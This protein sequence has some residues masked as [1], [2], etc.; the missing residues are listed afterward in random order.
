VGRDEYG[1]LHSVYVSAQTGAGLELLR[2]ALSETLL[3][4]AHDEIDAPGDTPPQNTA[5]SA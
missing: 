5:L 1:K 4:T 2:D 3:G